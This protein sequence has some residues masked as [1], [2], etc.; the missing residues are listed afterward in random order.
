MK[1][2]I[3]DFT[4]DFVKVGPEEYRC[5]TCN[6]GISYR[7][8]EKPI[9]ICPQKISV[10]NP[11]QFGITM[12]NV[13]SEDKKVEEIP[14]EPPS[15]MQKVMNFSKA[16]ANHA[17]AGGPKCTDEQIQERYNICVSC[18]FFKNNICTKCG[19][20]LVREKIYMNKLAWADQSCPVG[21]WGPTVEK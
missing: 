21:K 5:Q 16:A 3:Y 1:M 11:E 7:G 2:N 13:H 4:C 15:L 10:N 18:E 8:I 14:S 20:N 12:T 6:I 17:V 9:M 19:C